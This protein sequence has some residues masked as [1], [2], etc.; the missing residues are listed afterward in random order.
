MFIDTDLLDE[1][2]KKLDLVSVFENLEQGMDPPD[3]EVLFAEEYI[4]RR[5]RR[6]VDSTKRLR[7]RKALPK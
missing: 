2:A 3:H 6:K 7:A 5:L 4:D 1:I